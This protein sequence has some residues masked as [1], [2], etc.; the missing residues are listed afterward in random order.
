MSQRL[1]EWADDDAPAC[2]YDLLI[3]LDMF[4]SAEAGE[5]VH[6]TVVRTLNAVAAAWGFGGL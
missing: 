1:A 6:S 2:I 4:A 5:I 3:S